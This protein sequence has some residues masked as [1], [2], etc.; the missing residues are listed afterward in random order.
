MLQALR[1]G[2]WAWKGK[3]FGNRVAAH[4][5]IHPSLFHGA[6]EE[7]GCELHLIKLY[8]LKQNGEPLERV[9]HHSCRFLDPGLA[10]LHLRFGDQR[11][12]IEARVKV[13]A[14]MASNHRDESL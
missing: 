5:G 10:V 9:A 8:H 3:A 14:Y 7:G 2:Y 13:L 6:M 4:L 1:S 12:I 11:L